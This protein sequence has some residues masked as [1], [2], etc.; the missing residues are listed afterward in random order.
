MS[1]SVD[2]KLS[3]ALDIEYNEKEIQKTEPKAIK[4]YEP[5]LNKDYRDVRD[6]LHHI[7]DSGQVAIDGI[8]R[9]A[10]EGESPRA[11]E[12]VSQLIK[13]VSEANKDLIDL[14]KKMKDIKKED[15]DSQQAHNITN[16]T[17]FVG[18]TKE[19]QDMVKKQAKQIQDDVIDVEVIDGKQ[20]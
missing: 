8:L 11:Y 5:E 16:N 3:E 20:E 10:S 13:S 18:S 15:P 9:V 19:L 2:Q 17:L 7:I 1:K 6:N 4:P 12:V 14:H